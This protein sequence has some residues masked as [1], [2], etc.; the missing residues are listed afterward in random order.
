MTKLTRKDT[1]FE[2]SADQETSFCKLK[3]SLISKPILAS[4]DP[5]LE[6]EI[7]T[8]A[9][10]KGLGGIFF[11]K[12]SDGNLKPV[13]YFSRV[14]S[15]AEKFYHSYELETLAATESLKRFRIYLVGQAF[16]IVTDCAAVR[17]TFS[18]KDL[19]PRIARWWLAIQDY[20]FEIIHKPGTAMK[21]V[22]A[23]SRNPPNILQI[24]VEDWFL[25]IQ[26]Q[27]DALQN[28]I[29]QIKAKP[30]EQLGREYV[31]QN[32]RLYR[33]TLLG[34]RLVIPK[35]AKFQLLKK[36]HDELGHPGFDR[37]LK[38][39]KD[40]FWF[41]KMSRFVK[42]YVG[43][44]LQC[45]YSKGKYG[46]TEGFLHPIPKPNVPMD[47]VHIDHVGPFPKSKSGCAYVL[48]M[49]DSF[50]KF[51]VAKPSKTLKSAECIKHLR[52][53][54]G[55]YLGYPKRII[56]DNGLAF[57][58]RYFKDFVNSKQIKHVLTATATPRANGQVERFHRTLLD[59]LRA[60]STDD[61][62]HWDDKIPEVIWGINNTLNSSTKHT[63]F[64]LLF[65]YKGNLLNNLEAAPDTVDFG[66]KRQK[67]HQNLAGA[68]KKM[69]SQYDRKR[70]TPKNYEKGDLVLWNG[71]V[72]CNEKGVNKK[73]NKKYSGPYKVVKV[74]NG[75]RY[76]LRSVKGMRGYKNFSTLVAVDSIRPYRSCFKDSDETDSDDQV[77]DREDLVDLL[78]S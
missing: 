66:N 71:G 16:K 27:D 25:T 28:I 72:S 8:D 78:E 36:Y 15:S 54:F 75:D 38:L 56:S 7:H 19:N 34:E 40:Q 9:S 59:A 61:D 18:K 76:R 10:S 4:Y 74:F 67:A 41:S 53:I 47:T 69:K 44:C 45:G 51:V 63:P 39:I 52:A 17:Y 62:Q 33:R 49:V 5:S 31:Y 64:E 48:T 29:K 1:P 43:S 46:K 30:N 11:Q 60:V 57:T 70:K 3:E 14:T 68:T 23:L 13:A 50:T 77:E 21:H 22:D 42:K 55:E 73:L 12:S 2:W 6:I 65:G 35:M 58:S 24:G 26:M 20:D 32:N 37:C